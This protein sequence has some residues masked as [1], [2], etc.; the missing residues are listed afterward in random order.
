M[1]A[2]PPKPD[3]SPNATG[4]SFSPPPLPTGWFVPSHE[5]TSS[6][7]MLM[8]LTIPPLGSLNGTPLPSV[9]TTFKPPRAIRLGRFQRPR[10][11][12]PLLLRLRPVVTLHHPRTLLP[13]ARA[14]LF[15]QIMDPRPHKEMARRVLVAAGLGGLPGACS[16]AGSRAMDLAGDQG[17]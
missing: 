1:V 10:L 2:S 7:H 13:Q 3:A 8:Q 11:P 12:L 6:G 4:P 5:N 15:S 16:V 17:S 14:P 9:T